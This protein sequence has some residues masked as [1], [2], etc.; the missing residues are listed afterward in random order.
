ML[1]E[2]GKALRKLRIDRDEY[3]KDMAEKLNISVAYLS[4]IETGKRKIPENLVGR[5]GRAYFLTAGEIAA[6]NLLKVKSDKE[7]RIPLVRKNKKQIEVILRFAECVGKMDKE[8]L[9]KI[10][11]IMD[12]E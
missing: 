7:V 5:I 11:Q 12:D 8:K 4:A 2:F 6:L 9:D 3:I 10:V 1:T